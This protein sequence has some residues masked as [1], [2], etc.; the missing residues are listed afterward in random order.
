MAWVTQLVKRLEH[1]IDEDH[2]ADIFAHWLP[3]AFPSLFHF[4]YSFLKISRAY[5]MEGT[6]I[7]QFWKWEEVELFVHRSGRNVFVWKEVGWFESHLKNCGRA[8]ASFLEFSNE[9]SLPRVVNP[10][11]FS[12]SLHSRGEREKWPLKII[13]MVVISAMEKSEKE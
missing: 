3:K 6:N 10:Y 5:Y 11:L 9:L 12:W 13:W 8:F 4:K 1:S 7:V 2:S